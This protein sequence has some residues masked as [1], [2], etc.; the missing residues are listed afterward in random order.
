MALNYQIVLSCKYA[1]TT[2]TQNKVLPIHWHNYLLSKGQFFSLLIFCIKQ[3][4]LPIRNFNIPC[5]Q[6]T[7]RHLNFLRLK[8]HYM[9]APYRLLPKKR[10][11]ADCEFEKQTLHL[12]CCA[13]INLW[14][15]LWMLKGKLGYMYQW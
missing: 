2:K 12:L 6:A 8:S 1:K 4:H 14:W 5:P 11:F 7:P 13:W 3:T 9:L 10:C 15:M